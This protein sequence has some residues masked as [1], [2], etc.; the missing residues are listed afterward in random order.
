MASK[1]GPSLLHLDIVL[2]DL[3]LDKRE[4]WRVVQRAPDYIVNRSG[5]VVSLKVNYYGHRL[6]KQLSDDGYMKVKLDG[7]Y[8]TVARL[9]A[10]T[11]VEG[12]ENDFQVNHKDGNKLNNDLDNL[13]WVSQRDNL[14]HAMDNGLHANPRRK[15]KGTNIT[16]GDEV[17]FA[18]QAEASKS[19]FTQANISKCLY[20]ERPAHK[21]YRWEFTE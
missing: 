13:E 15:I 10:E 12:R 17:Y 4:D 11:Y 16:T 14:Y 8:I 20:G 6:T 3:G 18:S 1:R 9:L 21:G 2:S 5:D 19:G 7:S